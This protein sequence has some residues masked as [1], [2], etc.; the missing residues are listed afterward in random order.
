MAVQR[1]KVLGCIMKI[2]YDFFEA[3]PSIKHLWCLQEVPP[4][5]HPIYGVLY[6][7][8]VHHIAYIIYA[9]SCFMYP[10]PYLA[11]MVFVTSCI[12]VSL[13]HHMLCH[14]PYLF[15]NVYALFVPLR[16]V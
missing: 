11:Y 4:L 9:T 14:F 3:I 12:Y 13:P 8:P 7:T 6:S 16:I 15:S 5:P 1:L 2:K 10:I